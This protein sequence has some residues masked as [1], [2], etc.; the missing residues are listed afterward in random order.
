MYYVEYTTYTT[1]YYTTL[2]CTIF[3]ILYVLHMYSTIVLNVYS[4]ATLG[5][6]LTIRVYTE[7]V[8][9]TQYAAYLLN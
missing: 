4:S 5:A 7:Y 6:A 1:L 3:T 2:H 8:H 9:T